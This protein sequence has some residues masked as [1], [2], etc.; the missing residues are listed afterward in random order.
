MVPTNLADS[1][2]FC[3]INNCLKPVFDDV[4]GETAVIASVYL[5]STWGLTDDTSGVWL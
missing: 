3:K 2:N 4:L 1:V 5:T